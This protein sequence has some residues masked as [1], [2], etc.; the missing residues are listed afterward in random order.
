[1]ALGV[2]EAVDYLRHHLR[3]AG[4]WPEAIVS[5]EALELLA[6]QTGGVPR[7]LNQAAHQALV[8]ADI[9]DNGMVDVEAVLEALTALGLQEVAAAIPEAPADRENEIADV[10]IAPAGQDSRSCLLFEVPRP[11]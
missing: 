9:A 10:E 8:L 11:A 2:E 6:R 7:L 1:S 4:G 3:A 5:E